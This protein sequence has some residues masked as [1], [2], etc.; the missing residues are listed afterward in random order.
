MT[1][2]MRAM[3][4]TAVIVPGMIVPGMIVRVGMVVMM[5]MRHGAKKP[6]PMMFRL[7]L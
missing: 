7:R 5:V 1:V 2:A 3:I 4:M 6:Q